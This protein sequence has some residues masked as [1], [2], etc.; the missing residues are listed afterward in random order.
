MD[1]ES[2]ELGA[3]LLQ[4][5]DDIFYHDVLQGEEAEPRPVSEDPGVEV[6]RIVTAE[7]HRLQVG[8]TVGY[9]EVN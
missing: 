1:L 5:V 3:H 2:P 4:A 6:A 8:T 7:K 9:N